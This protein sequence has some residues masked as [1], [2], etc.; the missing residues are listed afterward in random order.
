MNLEDRLHALAGDA[1]P[2]TPD[3]ARGWATNVP[4]QGPNVAQRWRRKGLAVAIATAFAVPTALAAKA[5][6]TPAHIR[7]LHTNTTPSPP[8][9]ATTDLGESV[10]TTRAAGHK[11]G[12]TIQTLATAPEAIHV[13]HTIVTLTYDEVVITEAPTSTATPEL[14]LKTVGPDTRVERVSVGGAPGYFL[15]GAPHEIGYFSR[16]GGFA[17]IPPRLAGTTL[18]FERDGLL[19]R[20][21]G[22]RLTKRRA[23]ALARRLSA[24]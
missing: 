18:A 3:L 21:E 16:E 7:I 22:E 23:L 14:M 10:A 8:R 19:I 2:P 5:L 13:D 15:T 12:F 24:S 9:P 4:S 11:A 1:F 20:I 17:L 6:L